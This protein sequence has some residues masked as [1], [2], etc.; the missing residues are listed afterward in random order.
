[1]HHEAFVST[2]FFTYTVHVKSITVHMRAYMNSH[3]CGETACEEM[4]GV[5]RDLLAGLH[6]PQ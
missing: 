6:P 2:H 5:W 3:V 1:M 4:D